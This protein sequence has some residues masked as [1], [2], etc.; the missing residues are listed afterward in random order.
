MNDEPTH[1]DADRQ[2]RFSEKIADHALE[3][4]QFWI[5]LF[6]LAVSLF[7]VVF[8]GLIAFETSELSTGNLNASLKILILFLSVLMAA[9]TCIT[10]WVISRLATEY[11]NRLKQISPINEHAMLVRGRSKIISI[12]TLA[13]FG[14]LLA[15]IV[16]MI[17]TI[18][19]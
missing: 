9:Y 2:E 11:V 12:G 10:W 15:L 16:L 3:I 8:S 5:R 1:K 7:L 18:R 13:C 6:V 14:G 17:I 4:I 19:I